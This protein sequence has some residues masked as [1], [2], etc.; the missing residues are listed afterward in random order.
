MTVHAINSSPKFFDAFLSIVH[1][2]AHIL[3]ELGLINKHYVANPD[4]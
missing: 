4:K 3:D 2:L 1:I